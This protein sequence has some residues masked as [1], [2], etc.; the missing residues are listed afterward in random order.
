MTRK[1]LRTCNE[2]TLVEVE[3]RSTLERV[4]GRDLDYESNLS[5]ATS[6]TCLCILQ[7]TPLNKYK[8]FFPPSFEPSEIAFCKR[9]IAI[10]D[11]MKKTFD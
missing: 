4:N 2:H 3:G 7:V 5:T 6:Y 8:N 10:R 1:L 9:T 11:E